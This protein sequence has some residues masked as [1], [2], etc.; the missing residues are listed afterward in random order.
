MSLLYCN[1]S[2]ERNR[3]IANNNFRRCIGNLMFN[4]SSKS[5]S[6][7]WRSKAPSMPFRAKLAPN[8][9]NCKSSSTQCTTSRTVHSCALVSFMDPSP[10]PTA[11]DRAL[12]PCTTPR[13]PTPLRC[14]CLFGTLVFIGELG[15]RLPALGNNSYVEYWCRWPLEVTMYTSKSPNSAKNWRDVP[16]GK[17]WSMSSAS[18]AMT[19]PMKSVWPSVAAFNTAVLS[20]LAAKESTLLSILQAVKIWSF[21]VIT[22]A[23]NR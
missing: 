15:T 19:R 21:F 13:W 20:E 3:L 6:D 22:E 2:L 16:S 1:E 8:M 14:S 7:N 17:I 11:V 23:P 9:D 10:P 18:D 5:R 4:M 12:R